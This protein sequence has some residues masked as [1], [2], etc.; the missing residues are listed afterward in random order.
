MA[1]L[2]FVPGFLCFTL[3]AATPT[4][5]LRVSAET[6]PPGGYA[7]FKITVAAPAQIS[8]AT[9]AMTFDPTV[10][11]P[12]ASIS[13]FSATGDQNGSAGASGSTLSATVTSSSASLGQLPG[14]PVF[15][16]TVPILATAKAGTSTITVDPT[17]GPWK[18]QQG[19]TYL[20]T[21]A[22]ATFTVGGT[23]S[24][25][26]ATPGGG[27]LPSGTVVAINGT[28]FD[29]TTTVGISGVVIQSALVVSP[30]QINVTL[31]GATEMTG[32]DI[33]LSNAA[34]DSVDYF[35]SLQADATYANFT[36]MLLLPQLPS[37]QYTAV[38]WDYY[39]DSGAVFYYSCLQNP[40]PF[41]VTAIYY[42]T[43][44]N[45]RTTSQTIVIPPY[46][47]YAANNA[48]FASGLGNLFMTVS[49]PIRMAEDYL[50]FSESD[51]LTTASVYPPTQ[52]TGL[53]TLGANLE[54]AATV[55]LSFTWQVGT[56]APQAQT[57]FVS[58]GLPF[59]VSVSGNGAPYLNVTP[60]ASGANASIP[61][62]IA[63][64]FSGLMPGTYTALVTITP[65]L[66]PGLVQFAPGSVSF[67]VTIVATAQP[68]IASEGGS[69]VPFSMTL[70]GA[71]PASQ[72]Y[73]VT[74]N[75][76]PAAFSAAVMPNSGT[77]L[78]VTPS[79]GTTPATLTLSVNPAGL[80]AGTYQ[81]GFFIQ[82]PANTL[83]VAVT[84]TITAASTAPGTLVVS[85]TS[86]TFSL[87]PGQTTPSPTQTIVIQTPTP[88]VT[89]SAS[90]FNGGNWLMA[91]LSGT[92]AAQVYATAA[93]LPTG[94]YT[95]TVTITSPLNLVAK[96]PVTL[97]VAST[98]TAQFTVAPSTL[99]LTAAAGAIATGTINVN[100]VSGNP[101]FTVQTQL[102]PTQ[103][104][105]FGAIA[106]QTTA[107]AS[108]QVSAYAL[109]PGTYE[110]GITV[111][112]SGGSA[113]IIVSL[114]VT[115]TPTS[116]PVMTG[117]VNA[118]S[119]LSGPIA[120]G[121]II[122]IFGEG[123]TNAR[124]T[125]NG[126]AAQVIYTSSGQVNAIVP[127]TV[128]TDSASIQIT[129]AGLQSGA[130]AV[131]I[132]N[133]TPGIF[134]YTGT[135]VGQADIIDVQGG[136]TTLPGT[137]IAILAT[138][139]GTVP[140]PVTVTIG[141]IAAQV[142]TAAPATN[143]PPGI[144][145]ITAAVPANVTPGIAVPIQINIGGATSQPGV[146]IPIQ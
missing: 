40:N 66:P 13:S 119:F 75:G 123:L 46:G 72:T 57:A 25:Q 78:S 27:L 17:Q 105:H 96:V 28:G 8:T 1:A 111:S 21:P 73:P 34:G 85:P 103:G 6:A 54:G 106:S 91:S 101:S 3:A 92:V 42:F 94:T 133:S 107:P 142:F 83:S 2:R 11:G 84:L 43:S 9:I 141:G 31:G 131:P 39:T 89:V 23:L 136:S 144:F 51:Q 90:T 116:P 24:V 71:A 49:A 50:V 81:S 44:V 138:G 30:T 36:T 124:V 100:V 93:N 122:A 134:T 132:T 130:W 137:V 64:A 33:H 60:A 19:D 97:T 87:T 26:S 109:V 35:A 70:G 115:A 129:S 88:P 68:F 16:V 5:G 18:D 126:I 112:W 74:T 82:G 79:S 41:A 69:P 102:G 12:V 63:P 145:E 20:I 55:S 4:L 52:L 117:I 38:T 7:Q 48:S 37:P 108:I 32:E 61:L 113:E 22:S 140:P 15:V 80:S 76:N 104:L 53:S 143:L 56:P 45:G 128:G 98:G 29:S 67:S 47:L 118:A 121:E 10:F 65:Q 77:W 95:G 58:S 14:Q 110:G 99:T 62:S 135:G 127:S 86:L 139:A 120:E 59:T 114:V 146:T 125:I